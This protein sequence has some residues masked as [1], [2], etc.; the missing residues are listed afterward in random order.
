MFVIEQISCL[1]TIHNLLLRLK[2]KLFLQYYR[3]YLQLHFSSKQKLIK[4]SL[5]CLLTINIMLISLYISWNEKYVHIYIS[6]DVSS[7]Y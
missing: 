6:T 4:M 2:L 5:Q 1:E 7:R 3:S